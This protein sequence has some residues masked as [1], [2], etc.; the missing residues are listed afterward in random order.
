MNHRSTVAQ[1]GNNANKKVQHKQ[2]STT[3]TKKYNANKTMQQNKANKKVQRK[4]KSTTQTKKQ[5]FHAGLAGREV[6]N[7]S[8]ISICC[9]D[10]AKSTQMWKSD[11]LVEVV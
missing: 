11:N 6:L 9:F 4:Q 7:T 5:T 10:R 3:Q 8:K 2:K 1:K